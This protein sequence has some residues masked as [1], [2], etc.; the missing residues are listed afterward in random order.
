MPELIAY[1]SERYARRY[2]EK[3][4]RGRARR[5]AS[6]ARRARP[7]S[8]RLYARNLYKLMA[9]KDEYEVARLHL[10]GRAAKPPSWPAQV[11]YL[12]HPPLLRA[13]GLKHKLRSRPG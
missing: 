10:L 5:G 7:R 11:H 4:V 2:A 12:L 13:M 9:Y 6:A 1:Q 8:P 3:V